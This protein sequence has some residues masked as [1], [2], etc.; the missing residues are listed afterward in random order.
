MYFE[1]ANA[2]GYANII[3]LE[4]E[5]HTEILPGTEIMRDVG[6]HHFV[7]SAAG[8]DRVL[9]PQ[10]SDDPHD[11]LVRVSVIATCATVLMQGIELEPLLEGFN[12]L[13]VHGGELCPGNGSTCPCTDVSGIDEGLR[14][15]PGG[16]GTVYGCVHSCVGV[17]EFLLVWHDS[18]ICD[19]SLTS[20][21]VPI[22][23]SFG[24]RPVLIFSTLICLVSNVW[25]AVAK[26]Y[27]SAMGAC[28]LNGFGAGPAEV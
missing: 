3:Q 18:T 8:S 20:N 15:R 13:A 24:R 14:Q 25:R 27:G 19:S 5:L 16:R 7:K 9:V 2:R 26:D 12:H 17:L 1:T 28:V 23:T 22:Q 21:R 11:P 10:P 6:S 4:E